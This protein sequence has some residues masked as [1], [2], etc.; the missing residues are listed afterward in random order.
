MT[1]AN[2]TRNRKNAK[3]KP[4]KTVENL[5]VAP[6][7]TK[8]TSEIVDAAI[9]LS[10]T[11]SQSRSGIPTFAGS[12]LKLQLAQRVGRHRGKF[13]AEIADVFVYP[14]PSVKIR[15]NPF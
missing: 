2:V 4:R 7:K 8:W 3:T 10:M 15:R 9:P 5:K 1:T 11:N 12:M 14:C 6:A 13:L